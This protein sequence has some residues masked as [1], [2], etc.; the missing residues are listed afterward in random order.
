MRGFSRPDRVHRFAS[1]HLGL[2]LEQRLAQR[3]RFL[4]GILLL[5]LERSLERST[6]DL[7]GDGSP[8]GVPDRPA[9]RLRHQH[10]GR[11]LRT[12]E[13]SI[14]QD[15]VQYRPLVSSSGTKT[16]TTLPSRGTR[17]RFRWPPSR[18]SKK[19]LFGSRISKPCQVPILNFHN[20]FLVQFSGG[21]S[22][23]VTLPSQPV[24]ASDPPSQL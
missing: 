15:R 19:T 6:F 14:E 3:N 10:P 24:Q 12:D 16:S 22:G 7:Q 11:I 1:F 21:Q 5:M 17:L 20:P 2:Q 9:G 18:S 8:A 13:P 4:K 23:F